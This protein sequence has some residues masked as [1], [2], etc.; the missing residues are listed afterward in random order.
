MSDAALA[1][2]RWRCRRGLLEL[3]LLLQ[4]FVDHHY[5]DLPDTERRAF[6]QLLAFPDAE[7]LALLQGG[8]GPD[9]TELAGIVATVRRHA[10]PRA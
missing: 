8:D 3:D 4:R 10:Q 5:A 1:R 6:E 2:A 7:L 9:N